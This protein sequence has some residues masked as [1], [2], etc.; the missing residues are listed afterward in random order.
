MSMR[1]KFGVGLVA[2]S[3]FAMTAC[4]G[5]TSTGGGD[6][7][8]DGPVE[9]NVLGYAALFD[10]KYTEAVIDQFNASQ[11]EVVANFVPAQNSSEMLG[12]LRSEASKPTVDVAILDVGVAHTG[13]QEGLFSK[14]GESDVPN[15]ADVVEMGQSAEGYGPAVTFDNLVVLYNIEKV[16]TPPTGIADLWTAKPNTVSI[17]APPDIQGHTLAILTS[18]NLGV[19]YKDGIE[20]A[21]EKLAELAPLVNTW[22]PVPDVYQPVIAGTSEYGIGW[23]ARAQ[24]FAEESDGAMGVVQP[25]D[26]IGFQINTINLVEGSE[27][28]DAAKE[29]MNYALSKEAQEA[30]AE[31]LFYAPVTSTAVLPDSVK[32]R[33]ADPADPSIVPI[34][35]IWIADVRDG[36]ADQWR[37]NVIGG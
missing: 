4:S 31:A 17:P 10:D 18:N 13:N 37:R 5:G 30:F 28:T 9:I 25:E 23:N 12:K 6:A 16:K 20:P 24:Y 35:W 7:G 29:F 8:G 36:W 27:K 26:G 2:V 21:I 15:L 11:D 3:I 22:E 14:V 32:D 34:D 1:K 19:D 33:V